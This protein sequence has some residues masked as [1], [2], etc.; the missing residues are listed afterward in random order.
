MATCP[1][2]QPFS[3]S[4]GVVPNVPPESAGLCD[5]Y[6][7]VSNVLGFLFYLI[8]PIATIMIVYGAFTL[9]TAA[10]NESKV[11]KGRAII[12]SALIGVAIVLGANV[13]IGSVFMAF[14]ISSSIL[15]W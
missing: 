14:G 7:L 12:I 4:T 5:F 2:P 1:S 8:T 3:F 11:K 9:M 15:P 6:Q 10:G 13:I